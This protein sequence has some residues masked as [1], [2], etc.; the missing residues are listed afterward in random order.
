MNRIILDWLRKIFL[1]IKLL[2]YI[3]MKEEII[4]N[5]VAYAPNDPNILVDALNGEYF[6]KKYAYKLPDS[7]ELTTDGFNGVVSN[8]TINQN[9]FG[10]HMRNNLIITIKT[11]GG[12]VH[13]TSKV[14]IVGRG[15]LHKPIDETLENIMYDDYTHIRLNSKDK[16]RAFNNQVKAVP[17]DVI[18]SQLIP[19]ADRKALV[20]RNIMFGVDSL[21]YKMFEGLNYTFGVELETNSGRLNEADVRGLNLKC[22]FDGSLRDTPDQRKEDVLG[23]EY[24][25]G[26]LKGDAGMYQLQKICNIL[27][28]K[29]TINAK[30][31]VHV[32]IGGINLNKENVIYLYKLG[33]LLQ[34]E[35]FDMLPASRRGNSYCRKLTPL[36]LDIDQ[37]NN[38]KTPIGYSILIDEYYNKVFRE[39]SS[40]K[41]LPSSRAN[42]TTNHPMGSKCGYNKATQRYCWLNFVTALFD[43]KNNPNAIT[44]EFRNHHGTLNYR[45]IKYWVKICMAFVAFVE[46]H[47]NSL[48]RGYWLDRDKNEHMITLHTVIKAVYPKS[49]KVLLNYIDERKQLFFADKGDIEALEYKN[50]NVNCKMLSMKEDILCV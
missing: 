24:I 42:K 33:E 17:Q 23:G 43:T 10:A 20:E 47:K 41:D 15:K 37:L 46:N 9:W 22:E 12:D 5:G 19:D 13:T 31:G 7:I 35:I 44:L 30:C 49:Y 36:K 4:I 14:K 50:D 27:S 32:H 26:V 29:C 1:K 11:R 48:K 6:L 21:T 16:F 2:K 28:E 3:L 40:S 25:T 18:N 45:K 8:I 38:I 34:D 39:V